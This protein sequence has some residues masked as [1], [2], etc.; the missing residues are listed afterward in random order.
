M[1]RLRDG[2]EPGVTLVAMALQRSLDAGSC[3]CG[4]PA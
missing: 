2:A 3:G 1:G 4:R